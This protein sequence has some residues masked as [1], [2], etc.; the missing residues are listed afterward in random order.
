M[1]YVDPSTPTTPPPTTPPPGTQAQDAA[2]RPTVDDVAALLRARTKNG[3]GNEVGTFDNTTRP[4]DIE[5][6]RLI[7]NGVAKVASVVGYTLP[8]DCWEEAAHLACLVAACQ[9][10]LSYWP[11]QVRTERSP[12]SMLW[13]QYQLD[14]GP[15]AEYVATVQPSGISTKAGTLYVASATT[16]FAYQFGFGTSGASGSIVP[17]DD[18]VNVG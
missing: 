1:S 5:V 12:Y 6:E 10:E 15:F 2:W 14:I 13:Q 11:E 3:S 7:T 18:I 16:N 4:T 8:D 17:L 9:I